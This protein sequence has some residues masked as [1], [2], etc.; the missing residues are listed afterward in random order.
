ME[1]VIIKEVGKK[2]E[3]VEV[4]KVTLEYMQGVV[5]GL[6]EIPPLSEALYK[7]GIDMV[8]NEEGKL[9]ELEPNMLVLG[10]EYEVLDVVVGNI[11]FVANDGEGRTIGLNNQQIEDLLNVFNHN[12]ATTNKGLFN[13]VLVGDDL[14]I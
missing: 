10:D 4:E 3:I 2:P 5:G 1:R 11:L 13:Y 8:I 9:L 7:R 12:L 14:W 6:I